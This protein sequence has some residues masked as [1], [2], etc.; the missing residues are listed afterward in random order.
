[1]LTICRFFAVE[2]TSSL[3]LEVGQIVRWME[4][5]AVAAAAAAAAVAVACGARSLDC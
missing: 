2:P 5:E 4:W 1:M 3:T